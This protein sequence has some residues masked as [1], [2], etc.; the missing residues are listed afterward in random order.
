MRNK[1]KIENIIIFTSAII[2]LLIVGSII[3]ITSSRQSLNSPTQ[4][5]LQINTTPA[6][7]PTQNILPPAIINTQPIY[8]SPNE[9]PVR[10]DKQAQDSL[11]EKLRNRKSLSSSDTAAKTKMLSLLPQGEQ[12]GILHA[13][14]SAKIEYVNSADMFI[15]EILTADINSA[16][17]E[18]GNW[19]TNQGFSQ[20]AICNYPIMFYLNWEI[21]NQIKNLNITFNPLPLNCQ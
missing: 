10:H 3:Y 14:A 2:L 20:D 18:A 16:K 12:S 5:Q 4:Q 21:S 9:P 19:F 17:R 7:Q 8:P 6:P 11:L 15:V 1:L 13:T